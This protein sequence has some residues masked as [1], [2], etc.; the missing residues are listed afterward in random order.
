ML[1]S[2]RSSSFRWVSMR[3]IDRSGRSR[4]PRIASPSENEVGEGMEHP[5][6][7][8][9]RNIGRVLFPLVIFSRY[10]TKFD[11]T[12]RLI[13]TRFRDED[14][15]GGGFSHCPTES[16]RLETV[17]PSPFEIE[18]RSDVK[19]I[20]ILLHRSR[21]HPLIGNSPAGM[22]AQTLVS[23]RRFSEHQSTLETVLSSIPRNSE[24]RRSAALCGAPA[25]VPPPLFP[26]F[27]DRPVPV[28]R[29]YRSH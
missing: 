17:G 26:P 23:G 6:G 24:V 15:E 8:R 9:C 21:T 13:T 11:K 25:D 18:A 1:R 12:N 29:S 14:G 22:G 28:A 3:A 20:T 7:G 16:V 5:F 19:S 4:C 2:R 10:L 27:D